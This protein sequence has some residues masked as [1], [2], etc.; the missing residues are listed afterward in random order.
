M[1]V[2]T[3][4]TRSLSIRNLRSRGKAVS[5][6]YCTICGVRQ[7][8][9]DVHDGKRKHT[10]LAWS[11]FGGGD[12]GL[13]IVFSSDR[14]SGATADNINRPWL[15]QDHK[16]YFEALGNLD[17]LLG[18]NCPCFFG[19]NNW[20]LYS[21][22]RIPPQYQGASRTYPTKKVSLSPQRM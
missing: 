3:V 2:Q 15:H 9:R 1:L 7:N 10:W 8:E 14:V 18:L 17:H 22:R 13:E 19:S 11:T 12:G 20:Y 16:T 21:D 4:R 6:I 5:P